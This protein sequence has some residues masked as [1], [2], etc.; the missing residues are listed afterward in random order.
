MQFT[1]TLGRKLSPEGFD[2]SM[3]QF[4][5]WVVAIL[6]LSLGFIKLGSMS[7]TETELFFG[8]LLVVTVGL[9]CVCLGFLLRIEYNTRMQSDNRS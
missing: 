1:R 7:L 6:V 4:A 9:L 5:C 2:V 8:L 3:G